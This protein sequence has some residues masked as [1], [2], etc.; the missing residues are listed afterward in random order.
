VIFFLRTILTI[1]LAFII[2]V[3]III[4]YASTHTDADVGHLSIPFLFAVSVAGG[5][6]IAFGSPYLRSRKAQKE[7][8][9]KLDGLA[10]AIRSYIEGLERTRTFAPVEVPGL[11]LEKGEFAIRHD[12]A[13]LAEF[14]RARVGGGVGTRVRVAGFPIY[15]G[16][17]K[18]VPNEELRQV[19]VGDLVLTNRRFLFVGAHSVVI[20]LDKLLS[21][22]QM[23]TGLIISESKGKRPHVFV[24]DNA[25]LWNFLVNWAVKSRFTEPRL[26]DGM[27]LAV[28]S[29]APNLEIEVSIDDTVRDRA[30]SEH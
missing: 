30:A 27:H 2:Y 23:D 14:M 12:R 17:Y 21:C 9:K 8:S 13:T 15:L 25:G 11:H 7:T 1:F 4:A 5:A 18:S 19:G 20:P 24:F 28:T 26:P 29:Q 10:T 6:L 16:G 22:Q 3:V